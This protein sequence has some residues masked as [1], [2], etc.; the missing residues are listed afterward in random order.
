MYNNLYG[1][2]FSV[3]KKNE[4]RTE[5]RAKPLEFFKYLNFKYSI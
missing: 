5:G 4:G 1:F 2:L 3:P